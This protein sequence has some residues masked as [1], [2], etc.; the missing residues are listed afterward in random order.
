MT[1]MRY[2]LAMRCLKPD[3]VRKYE[4]QL[5][6]YL[7]F[8]GPAPIVAV[9]SDESCAL[10]VF[11][12]MDVLCQAKSTLKGRIPAFTYG[13][14]KYTGRQCETG[15]HKRYSVLAMIA[16]VIDR[17]ADDVQRKVPVGKEGLRTCYAA[18]V[19]L[20]Q[21]AIAIQLWAWWTVSYGAMLRCSEAGRIQ[22][23]DVIFSPER[24]EKGT[25]KT[26]IITIRALEDETFKTHQC[27]VEFRFTALGTRG[28][29]P[30][31]AMWG[32]Y[33]MSERMFGRAEG[34]VFSVS[35]DWVRKIFQ[36]V[37]STALGGQ[38]Q[39]FGLHSLRAGG[40]TDAEELG[41]SVSEIMFMGR[42]RSPTVLVYLRSGERWL[43]QMGLRPRGGTMVRPT[44]FRG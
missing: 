16:R 13:V 18:M 19:T 25:P 8:M 40:A 12:C 37:A 10:W 27:S 22:W 29:C 7:R 23:Q 11:H 38:P 9:W 31:T 26:M 43:H 21:P 5:N 36:Q 17:K 3:T 4:L 30:V 34:P 42:W 2:K 32:W 39:D 44:L 41:W 35:I 6:A 20:C 33:Q 15:Q 28:V 24:T 14:F 1:D